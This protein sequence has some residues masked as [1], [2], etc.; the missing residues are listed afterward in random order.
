MLAS[1]SSFVASPPYPLTVEGSVVLHQM[2]RVSWKSWRSLEAVERRAIL[3]EWELAWASLE[4]KG[5]AAYSVLGHK[6]DLMWVHFRDSFPELTELQHRFNH[7]RFWDY[8]E[9]S[10]SYVSA[11]ELGLYE[12]TAKTY[13][14]L[15]ERGVVPHS[16]EWDQ[17]VKDVLARQKETFKAR[18]YPGVPAGKFICFYPMNKR[19]GESKNWYLLSMDERVRQLGEHGMAG[20]RYAG[21]VKQIISGSVGFDDWEWGVDLFGE[22]PLAFKK[23]VYEMRFDEVSALYGEFGPFYIG[24]RLDPVEFRDWLSL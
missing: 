9:P 19:R 21:V 7:L 24:Q 2:V 10:S 8:L 13:A 3:E 1:K 18:L 12:T 6:A 17:E 5:S 4:S 22:D 20:R 11:V 15:A 23:L 16:P 14:G